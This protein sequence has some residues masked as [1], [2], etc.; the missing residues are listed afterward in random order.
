MHSF[1]PY[2]QRR[3]KRRRIG[4]RVVERRTVLGGKNCLVYN[5]GEERCPKTLWYKLSGVSEP[6]G[7]RQRQ[8]PSQPYPE[9]PLRRRAVPAGSPAPGPTPGHTP[10]PRLLG[11]LLLAAAGAGANSQAKA[12]LLAR[13]LALAGF[14]LPE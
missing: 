7:Q 5:S 10:P 12:P 14:A 3:R 6:S 13:S 11:K 9:I 2:V 4:G 1:H 8:P